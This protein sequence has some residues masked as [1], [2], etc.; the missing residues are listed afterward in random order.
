MQ[1][2]VGLRGREFGFVK[3]RT[4][5]TDADERLEGLRSQN[6]M[7]G[8]VFK[9]KSDPRVTRVGRVLRKFSIDELPQ[10]LLVLFGQMSLVGPRPP[11]PSEV[12]FY[13]VRQRRRLSMRPGL[14]CLWQVQGRSDVQFE[15]WVR[16][17]LQYIDRWS[18]LLDLKILLRTL[19]A[20]LSARG[21]S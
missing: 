21:A 4:M 14:T 18:L 12:G 19:P 20:V 8:P 7:T 5:Y 3:F 13:E 11:I 15:E 16:L 17:D 2:R 1:K 10:F 9:M 6:E